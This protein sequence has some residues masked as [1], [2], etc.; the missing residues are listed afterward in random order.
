MTAALP[1]PTGGLRIVRL[2]PDLLGTYGDDG[3][4]TV[5]AAR[6]SWRGVDARI[7]DV[8]SDDPV[9]DDAHVYLI[10]GGEDGP[11]TRA[12]TRLG[13]SGSLARAIDGGAAMLAVCA[14]FQIMGAS[15]LGP[16]GTPSEGLGLL[17]ATTTRGTGPRIVG[18][19]L[20]SADPD[21]RVGTLSGYENHAGVTTV[22]PTARALGTVQVGVGNRPDDHLEGVWQG[23][24]IA[25]YLHGPVLARNPTLADRLLAWAL[26][27]DDDRLAPLDDDP[28][29]ALRAV[30]L[31]RAA[32]ERE[33][34]TSAATRTSVPARIRSRFG[35]S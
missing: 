17:D 4:A 6:A 11:Q 5:L 28:I 21:L 22:G 26:D 24:I 8:R 35:R 19:V 31:A 18:E 16:D 32:A 20:V 10:G 34:A 29:D 30:R 13:E 1:T 33:A 12:A 25:T 9:P 23:R 2:F 7:I 15:F 27:V 3:N 14:G